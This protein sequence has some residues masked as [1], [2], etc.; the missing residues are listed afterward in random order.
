MK[1]LIDRI[2]FRVERAF[3]RGT[4]GA[5]HCKKSQI[6]G[7]CGGHHLPICNTAN[8]PFGEARQSLCLK[9]KSAAPRL[10]DPCM[11]KFAFFGCKFLD[12]IGHLNI[13]F[14]R[15]SVAEFAKTELN[16]LGP[17]PRADHSRC[18]WQLQKRWRHGCSHGTYGA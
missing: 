16:L 2:L 12:S 9:L 17:T 1:L 14:I 13:F 10:C 6:S 5:G 7:Q 3:Q 4:L 18:R 8:T 15:F 11:R